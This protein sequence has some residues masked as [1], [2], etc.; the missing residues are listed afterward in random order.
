MNRRSILRLLGL[1]P[2]A[3]PVALAAASRPSGT[4][5]CTRVV[6]STAAIMREASIRV[7]ADAAFS[8]QFD[9]VCERNAAHDR[10]GL[11]SPPFG[12]DGS[13]LTVPNLIVGPSPTA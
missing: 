2:I 10:P 7:A 9:D 5:P 3:A 11:N 8:Q 13:S 4:P 12:F 6:A 1:A